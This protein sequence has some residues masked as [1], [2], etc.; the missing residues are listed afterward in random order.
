MPRV[1][2]DGTNSQGDL[3]DH[4]N[5]CLSLIRANSF[6]GEDCLEFDVVDKVTISDQDLAQRWRLFFD[7]L[8]KK[9]L[10][11]MFPT[12][13]ALVFKVALLFIDRP[14]NLAKSI[15]VTLVELW[16]N[17]RQIRLIVH[18]I[19]LD[20]L[21]PIHRLKFGLFN[22]LSST[23]ALQFNWAGNQRWVLPLLLDWASLWFRPAMNLIL[24]ARQE[25]RV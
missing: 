8:T 11:F 13:L 17:V 1:F 24:A 12:L 6:F 3:V 4:F 25:G 18:A 21:R 7:D 10:I 19:I 2:T 5:A 15:W 23:L 16:L 20:Y 22:L 14:K 9:F